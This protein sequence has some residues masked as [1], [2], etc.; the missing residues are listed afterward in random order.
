MNDRSLKKSLSEKTNPPA[1]D[2]VVGNA[3]ENLDLFSVNRTALTSLDA[4]L[5]KPGRRS[6][7]QAK[8]AKPEIDDE[9]ELWNDQLN[10]TVPEVTLEAL[11]K[12][13]LQARNVTSKLQSISTTRGTGTKG[14]SDPSSKPTRSTSTGRPSNIPTL[15]PSSIPTLRPSNAVRSSSA[16][17]K[18]TT[19]TAT[20]TASASVASPK[21]TVSRSLT[22]VSRK[23]P[24][25]SSTPSRN[26][27]SIPSFKK[28]GD[29][30]RSRS[31]TPRSKLQTAATSA[32]PTSAAPLSRTSTVR[33]TS[34]SSRP[35]V[36]STPQ[37]PPRGREKA[38]TL[39]FG[40][41]VATT[42][43]VTSPKRNISPNV[44]RTR[45]KEQ[46]ASSCSLIPSFSGVGQATGRAKSVKSSATVSDPTSSGKKVSKASVQIANN[47]MDARKGKANPFLGTML[48]PQSIKSYSRKW[49]GSSEGSSSSNQEE[50]EGKSL[51]KEENTEKSDS[52]RYESLLD[53]KDVKDTNW[54]LNLDDE[55]NH[56]LIFDSVFD[57][58][59]EPFSPL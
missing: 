56:S 40:R 1:D 22:P 38:V 10:Y 53:V 19:T 35:S 26:S 36:S 7:E 5:L 54:L 39:A 13:V 37:T 32:A 55:S 34:A 58:P 29:A 9:K 43:N 23:T 57:S 14:E 17:K 49:C 16:P 4:V 11:S 50:E 52:A 41:P 2:F 24:S 33:S 44:T 15:R 45:P 31:L 27:T 21:K 42:R 20:A 12:L 46:S 28:A 51:T 25:R 3:D 18:T 8:V 59:P 6:F 30:Q 48:Y 47:H